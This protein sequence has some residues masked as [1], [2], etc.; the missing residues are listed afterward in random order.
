METH[1]AYAVRHKSGVYVNIRWEPVEGIRQSFRRSKKEDLLTVLH[2][3]YK[4]NNVDDFTIQPIKVTY[5][6]DN[7]D[8]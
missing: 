7:G 4:P 3:H 5:Q 2:G 8:V 1:K 6:E